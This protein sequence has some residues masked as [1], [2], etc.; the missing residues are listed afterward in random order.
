MVVT[1]ND[2]RGVIHNGIAKHFAETHMGFV[3]CALVNEPGRNDAL[4][5]I[6]LNCS[7]LLLLEI[8][9][10]GSKKFIGVA[11]AMNLQRVID[12]TAGV[13]FVNPRGF[14][15]ETAQEIH[16]GCIF[17]REKG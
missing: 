7:E 1:N 11:R 8:F 6:E 5:G 13:R 9:H 10:F 17:W 4:F 2:A 16:E 15:N 14:G 3:E 12:G